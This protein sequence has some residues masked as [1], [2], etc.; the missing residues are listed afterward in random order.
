[1]ATGQR[2]VAAPG[3]H[4]PACGNPV[5]VH[6]AFCATCGHRIRD[7]VAV[8][9]ALK[10]P[11]IV[12][13]L[14]ILQFMGSLVWGFFAVAIAIAMVSSPSS[15]PGGSF[16]FAAVVLLFFLAGA[17]SLFACGIGL[18]KLKRYGRSLLR[19]WSI[20]GL[21]GFP[22]GTIISIII[23][24][25]LNTPGIKLLFSERPVEDLTSAEYATVVASMNSNAATVAVTIICVVVVGIF[26]L[27]I[28]AAIAIP[29][30]LRARIASNEVSTI[31]A[32]RSFASA[33]AAYAARNDGRYGSPECLSTP[34]RCLPGYTGPPFHASPV[35]R[36]FQNHGYLFT[37]L[38]AE[39]VD[40]QK[41][42]DGAARRIGQYVLLALPIRGAGTRLFCIDHTGIVVWAANVPPP[43]GVLTSCPA[44][45][46]PVSK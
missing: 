27:G 28:V 29:G 19:F 32:L 25:Y 9:V 4:C 11:A 13:V 18:L 15:V 2:T 44:G 35:E 34:E 37:F 45:W 22:V 42:F 8:R 10:R 40:P 14:A 3:M 12:T 30:L 33:E 6:A 41:S 43:R 20:L 23:L 5:A 31:A 39:T 36:T 1:M 21:I 38:S 17:G 16:A 7:D 46:Q 26:F 24:I